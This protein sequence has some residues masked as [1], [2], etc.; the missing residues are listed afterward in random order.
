VLQL[1]VALVNRRQTSPVAKHIF[2][3]CAASMVTPGWHGLR[4]IHRSSIFHHCGLQLHAAGRAAKAERE[5][6]QCK[7]SARTGR[8]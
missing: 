2:F 4:R 3:L 7:R 8:R 5:R 1:Q 6:Q